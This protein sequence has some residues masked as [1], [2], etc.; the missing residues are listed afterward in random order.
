MNE[1]TKKFIRNLGL[2]G[3]I[4]TSV[5]YIV[6]VVI[7]IVGFQT[8]EKSLLDTIVFAVVNAV[9]GFIIM[10]LLKIQGVSIAKNL[11]ENLEISR[12][13]YNT[14]TKDKKPHT[15]KFYW[16]TTV[17]KDTI[18]KAGGIGIAAVGMVK[19]GIDGM[20]DYTLLLL[21]CAN[22]VM[23]IC[24][25]LLG[26]SDAYDFYNNNQVPYM[27]EQLGLRDKVVD[28]ERNN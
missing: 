9:V 10:E 6:C 13:Y 17:P 3:A 7:L 12:K 24:F 14:K 21:A 28:S 20:G 11:P 22:L 4:L 26:L 27:K 5:V 15:M 16:L 2:I 25:G 18:L 1:L 19:I 23:F 8:E